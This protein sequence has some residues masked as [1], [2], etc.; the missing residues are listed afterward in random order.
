[1]RKDLSEFYKI[2]KSDVKYVS[3]LFERIF[4]NWSLAVALQPDEEIRRTKAHY[5]YVL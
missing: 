1:M 5:F 3:K 4:F 2:S